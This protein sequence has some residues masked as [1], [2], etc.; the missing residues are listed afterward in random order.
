MVSSPKRRGLEL[1]ES[2][3]VLLTTVASSV[4]RTCSSLQ[5]WPTMAAVRFDSGSPPSPL[6][7]SYDGLT[8]S[9]GMA[10]EEIERTLSSAKMDLWSTTWLGS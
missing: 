4:F 7:R 1:E 5:P 9:Q 3:I 6:R 2:A 8:F 10:S